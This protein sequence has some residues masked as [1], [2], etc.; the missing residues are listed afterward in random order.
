MKIAIITIKGF[1]VSVEA[2]GFKTTDCQKATEI[3][4]RVSGSKK[5]SIALKNT[6]GMKVPAEVR[7]G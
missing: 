6:H 7:G 2:D 5:Q 3:F 1:D 4:T